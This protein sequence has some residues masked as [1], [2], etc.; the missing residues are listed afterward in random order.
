MNFQRSPSNQTVKF[1][2][3][4][5]IRLCLCI[6]GPVLV[7]R[8]TKN[9]RISGHI[10][11]N[12]FHWYLAHACSDAGGQII[13]YFNWFVFIYSTTWMNLGRC[14]VFCFFTSAFALENPFSHSVRFRCSVMSNSLR[15]HGLQ[16]TRLPCLSP[17][18]ELAQTHVHQVVDA[19][20]PS[21]PL[22]SPPPAFNL[23]QHQ[24]LF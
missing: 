8:L 2:L 15:P 6:Q 5:Q 3:G 24:S 4:N 13:L 7:V 21:H 12:W 11:G 20:Q 1:R 17:T 22:S 19:I 10:A 23:C 9:F 14:G 16:H 18:P